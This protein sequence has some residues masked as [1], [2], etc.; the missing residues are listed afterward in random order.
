MYCYLTDDSI[1]FNKIF[2]TLHNRDQ[3]SSKGVEIVERVY[4]GVLFSSFL[5]DQNPINFK[6]QEITHQVGSFITMANVFLME[7]VLDRINKKI[8]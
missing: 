1:L 5:F 4:L 6:K 8:T 7:K 2:I 3:I